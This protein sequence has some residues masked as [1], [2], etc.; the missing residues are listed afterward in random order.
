M[1]IN[2]IKSNNLTHF[3]L[4]I[5]LLLGVLSYGQ[6]RR[7]Y[8]PKLH[9]FGVG[10]N[11]GIYNSFGTNSFDLKSKIQGGFGLELDYQYQFSTNKRWRA[12]FGLSYDYYSIGFEKRDLHNQKEYI[13]YEEIPFTFKYHAAKYQENW[14]N[15][16]ISIPLTIEYSGKTQ[17]A[18]Y[19][20]TGVKYSL[21]LSNQM[22]VSYHNLNTSGYFP[23]SDLELTQPEFLGFGNFKDFSKTKD[24]KLDNRLAWIGEIGIKQE[25]LSKH[26]LYIGFYFDIGL[27]DQLKGIAKSAN[28]VLIYNPEPNDALHATSFAQ[29]KSEDKLNLKT[30]STGVKL[31]YA[32]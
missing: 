15:Q 6:Y 13:D 20:R 4:V 30:Y 19:F 8:M 24:I 22:K 28:D 12:G 21:Q 26:K 2:H 18:F 7:P 32:F 3:I 17:T 10:V 25:L 14:T 1:K 11:G 16:Q 5:A 9:Q 27:N 23:L 31:R 29:V